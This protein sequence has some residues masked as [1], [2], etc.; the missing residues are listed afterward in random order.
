MHDELTRH[1]Q[2]MHNPHVPAHQA[3]A[4][5][6]APLPAPV[7]QAP[8]FPPM[9][10]PAAVADDADVTGYADRVL[11]V[12]FRELTKNWERNPI[13]VAMRNPQLVH[14]DLLKT[15]IALGPN[16]LP[17]NQ[18]AALQGTYEVI[19]KLV[20]DWRVFDAT[21]DPREKPVLLGEPSAETAARLP[22]AVLNKIG[23]LI[24]AAA[25]PQ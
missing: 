10:D 7:D 1:H 18:E 20:L 13:W 3:A 25:N 6:P 2:G 19:G 15:D 8:Y 14:P 21:V 5:P 16:G 22:L 11:T 9:P 12:E 17:V 23:K 4:F 24:E